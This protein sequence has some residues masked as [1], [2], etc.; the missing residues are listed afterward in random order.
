MIQYP[1]AVVAAVEEEVV[2]KPQTAPTHPKEETDEIS[3][4][5]DW[6]GGGKDGKS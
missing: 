2:A 6:G 4:D 1:W 5:M 3:E